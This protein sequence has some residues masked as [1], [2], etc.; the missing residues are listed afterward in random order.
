MEDT[1]DTRRWQEQVDEALRD[2]DAASRQSEV[3]RARAQHALAARDK[4]AERLLEVERQVGRLER[5]VASQTS[6]IEAMEGTLSWKV[7]YPLRVVFARIRR[8]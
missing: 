7:T 2:A 6:V 4:L 5:E 8:S 1:A 3:E